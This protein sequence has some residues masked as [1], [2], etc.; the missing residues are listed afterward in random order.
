MNVKKHFDLNI[1][2]AGSSI[3]QTFE[4]DKDITHINGLLLTCNRDD[5]L[6]YRGSQR[7]EVNKQELFP[8]G[9]ESK[10]LICG[11]NVSPNLRYHDTG[12]MPTGNRLVKVEYKDSEDSRAPFEPY[13]VRVYLS[14]EQTEM[15]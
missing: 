2:L 5:L 1:T 8:D 3:S 7:I 6:Y 4:L 9:Y 15:P 11:I 13:R 12:N 14:C 10:L